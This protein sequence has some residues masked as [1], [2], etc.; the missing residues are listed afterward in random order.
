MDCTQTRE[1]LQ[2]YV[3]G[4]LDP[5]TTRTVDQHLHGCSACMGVYRQLNAL[6]SSIVEGAPYHAAPDRLRERIRAQLNAAPETVRTRTGASFWRWF[7][8]GAVVA[9]TAVMTWLL[10]PQLHGSSP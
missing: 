10:T 6:R 2:C 4:E 8:L 3:D 9:A 1:Y 5:V 7:Q